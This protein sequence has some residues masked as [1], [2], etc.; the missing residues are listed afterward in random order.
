MCST[1]R[2]SACAVRL[3]DDLRAPPADKLPPLAVA[4]A[5]KRSLRGPHRAAL[6]MGSL[7]NNSTS[8]GVKPLHSGIAQAP[9]P[10]RRPHARRPWPAPITGHYAHHV[11][12]LLPCVFHHSAGKLQTILTRDANLSAPG[13]P[14]PRL[15][16]G[17]PAAFPPLV[18]ANP[19]RAAT[20]ELPAARPLS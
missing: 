10:R 18:S 5:K 4:R 6:G 16:M 8:A 19:V 13:A 12:G 15:Q 3:T 1:S 14:S 20:P 2:D 17:R 7:F 9:R 11:R